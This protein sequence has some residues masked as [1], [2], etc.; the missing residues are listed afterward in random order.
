MLEYKAIEREIIMSY[1]DA[2]RFDDIIN[3]VEELVRWY[4][5]IHFDEKEFTVFLANGESFVYKCSKEKIPHLL[6]I[7]VDD[8]AR[9]NLFNSTSAYDI[10]K[11]LCC[12]KVRISSKI[13]HGELK[14]DNVFSKHILD[15]LSIFKLNIS[16]NTDNIMFISKYNRDKI[17]FMGKTPRN[18]DYVMF[19]K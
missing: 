8:L 14:I 1:G 13:G 3:K 18:C 4:E 5:S 11:E 16:M 9:T 19:K 10:L 15:K 7:K 12:S 17:I 6:G 2:F